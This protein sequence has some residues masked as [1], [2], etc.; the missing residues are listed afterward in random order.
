MD[1]KNDS[2][3]TKRPRRPIKRK[4]IGNQHSKVEDTEFASTSAKKFQK[5]PQD[6]IVVE[7]NLQNCILDFYSVFATISTLVICA[8]CKQKVEFKKA[9]QFGVGF[10]IAVCCACPQKCI[11]SSPVI[12]KTCF[13]IN[14]RLVVAMRLL[15]IGQAGISM[16]CGLMD[17]AHKISNNMYYGVL[18][19]LHTTGKA[20]YDNVLSKAVEEEKQAM[21][22]AD[23]QCDPTLLTV[24]GDGS[25]KKRGFA[26]LFGVTT[27]I[28][29]HS[30]KVVDTVVKSTMCNSCKYWEAN[31]NEEPE[32]Y[33]I[34]LNSHEDECSVNHEGSSG[35]MEVDSVK[36]MFARSVEKH[37]VKYAKYIGDGDSKTFKGVLDLDPY[38]GNPTVIKKECIAHVQKRMGTRLRKAKKDNKGVGGRGAGKLTDKAI[39]ELTTYYGLAIRRNPDSV[40]DMKKAIW[41]TFLHKSSTDENPQHQNCPTGLSSWCAWQKAVAEGTVDCFHHTYAPLDKTVLN[42]IRPVYEALSTDELLTRCLGSETQ[43][44]NESFNSVLWAFNPKHIHAGA[45]TVEVASFIATC[46]F[47]EGFLTILKIMA[48]MGITIGNTAYEYALCRNDE[49]LS[50]AECKAKASSKAGRIARRAEN[51]ANLSFFEE[52]E[53]GLYGAGIAD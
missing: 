6:E 42:V 14:R 32:A 15:G 53:G 39:S 24:S 12:N 25:W 52:E 38:D 41:A 19:N 4:Y 50:R 46:I 16:F 7:N 20:V 5:N 33:E 18:Q 8:T 36:E 29:K 49:R 3:R 13:E 22:E 35:K 30:K 44:C 45:K 27:L 43:N 23:P 17:I 48:L 28:G 2:K 34:W 47:N 9:S 40:D 21:V 1:K 11:P 26:S 51:A 37:G 31:K 10:K